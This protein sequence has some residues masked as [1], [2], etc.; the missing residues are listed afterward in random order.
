MTSKN[1]LAVPWK[2]EACPQSLPVEVRW[3]ERPIIH[4]PTQILGH[5]QKKNDALGQAGDSSVS[6][7]RGLRDWFRKLRSI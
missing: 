6:R 2:C 7:K 4:T 1:F 3:N 5:Q